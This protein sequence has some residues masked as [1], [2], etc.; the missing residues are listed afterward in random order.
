MRS[1]G[2]LMPI[3]SLPSRYGIGT[4]GKEAFRFIDFLKT[5]GQTYWQI[6][7]TGKTGF[8]DSP[9]Q[10]V[11]A[12]A[13]NPYFVD[14]EDLIGQ[15]LL[16]KAECDAA[17]FGN[18][19]AA[20]DYGKLYENRKPL[21]KKAVERFWQ[22]GDKAAYIAFEKENETW[23]NDYALFCAIKNENGG[24]LADFESGLLH[25][26]DSAISDARERL[27]NEILY[28][29]TVQFWFFSQWKK[30][31][32]YAN[33][34]GVS[35][36]GDIPIY[37]SY[38]SADVWAQPEYF[39]LDG[40]LRPKSVAGCPPDAFSADGQLWG[41]PLYDYDEMARD[42]FSWWIKRLEHSLKLYDLI[43]IDHFRG[44]ESYFSIPAADKTAKGGK[45]VK[46]PG[47]ALF[48]A[49]EEKLG[50]L[51]LIAEDLGHITEPVRELLAKTGYPGMA[52]LQFA[53]D[54]SGD[55]RYLPHNI[56][57]NC[58]VYT[59][60]HDN[61]TIC[62]YIKS[63]S[64]PKRKFCIDYLRLNENEGYHWGMIKAAMQSCADI[65]ILCM[66]DFMGLDSSARINTPAT[67]GG[68][69]Q[70]RIDGGCIND[71]LAGII[72]DYTALYRRKPK[73]AFDFKFGKTD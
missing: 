21:L 7:P 1:C 32:A 53:F 4:L 52:V 31:R 9:Y 48:D 5:A 28:E 12:F 34:N 61:D 17:D 20:V 27:K 49:V 23:L 14:L 25:R 10:S 40:D 35:I 8:G 57:K 69:W 55:S 2:I 36:I 47:T 16:T 33:Q 11:S 50:K 73:K 59:G 64:E 37:V 3:F 51:P 18:D 56:T 54:P 58:A 72:N 46:G 70:W 41:N 29:K 63:C 42:G 26:D 44:F 67:N 15:E 65:C 43:R 30:L 68:N 13:G 6:L 24:S 22:K 45:W 62:G 71:W 66:Q 39:R 60:T 38:D 19:N